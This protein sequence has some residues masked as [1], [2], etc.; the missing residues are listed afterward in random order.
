MIK[1]FFELEYVGIKNI[2]IKIVRNNMILKNRLKN[3]L[4]IKTS[5]LY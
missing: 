1:G 2:Q 3:L 5:L 4:I